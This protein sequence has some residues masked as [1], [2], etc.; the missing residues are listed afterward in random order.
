MHACKKNN[1]RLSVAASSDLQAFSGAQA[2]AGPIGNQTVTPVS[3][4]QPAQVGSIRC[5]FLFE[6][7]GC[8]VADLDQFIRL[9]LHVLLT[10]PP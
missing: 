2:S 1:L 9:F 4:T 8:C 3:L 5:Q 7:A 6:H 10:L